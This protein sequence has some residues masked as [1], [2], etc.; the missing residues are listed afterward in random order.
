MRAPLLFLIGLAATALLIPALARVAPKLG[1]LD[2]PGGRKDHG[3]AVPL[4]GGLA[5]GAVFLACFG[6]FREAGEVSLW[7]GA[8]VGIMLLCGTLDDHREIGSLPKF[9][10]QIV[11][12]WL[13]VQ[14]GGATL[15]HLGDLVSAERLDL[16]AA[17][18]PFTVFAV[19]GVMNAINMAD[20]ID[21]LAGGLALVAVAWFGAAAWYVGAG[22]VFWVV[23]LLAGQLIAFLAF[24]AP[25][26][27]RPRARVFMGDAGSYFLG[28]V[29]AW[30]AIRLSM[31]E[32]AAIAPIAAVWILGIP[33]A[34]AV[35]LMLRRVLRGRS[36][37]RPDTEHLHHLLQLCG[38]S[39]AGAA[40]VMLAISI[41]MGA[42]GL[43]AERADVP[44]F[45]MFYIY[46][47]LW[48]VYYIV[49]SSISRTARRTADR[50]GHRS[51]LSAP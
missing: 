2:H 7:F 36:P 6:I 33:L 44:D 10:F 4:V 21:G 3:A 47:T 41:A 24:N 49:T 48:I 25:L 35:A 16:G 23:C 13:L 40:V 14:F 32:R 26:P 1:L 8:A 22:S 12:A 20:G 18:M 46:G 39:K 43:A 42:I 15:S 51:R 29:L 19:V 34:D 28:L 11:A 37:F 30:L 31:Q 5:M 9:G 50:A 38:L 27:H 45:V 17:A